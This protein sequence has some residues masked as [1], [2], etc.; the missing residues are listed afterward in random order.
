MTEKAVAISGNNSPSSM[1]MAAIDKG[2]DLDKLEKFMELQFKYEQ[3]QARKAYFEAMTAF[4][5]APPEIEKNKHVK[6]DTLKGKTEYDHATLDNVIEKINSAL[7]EHGLSASWTTKQENGN[8]TVTC[9]ISH[10]LGHFEETS[11]TASPDQSGGK[12]SIQALG[13]T[14]TYLERYTVLAL[15]GLATKGMDDDGQGVTEYITDK[16][17]ST[18]TDMINAKDVNLA[19]FLKYLDCESLEKIPADK[20]NAAMTALRAKKDK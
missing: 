12:N 5:A 4:K 8:V 10:V 15:T 3:N 17:L 16:Q 7:S 6:F 2:M 9:R 11:L 1:L 18:I 13:S 14:V 20:F 19:A